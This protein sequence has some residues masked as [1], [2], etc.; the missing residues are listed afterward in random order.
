[1]LMGRGNTRDYPNIIK[2]LA[3]F[4][5]VDDASEDA[6]KVWGEYRRYYDRINAKTGGRMP[7]IEALRS[8]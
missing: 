6:R 8:M 5:P 4:L 3:R 1:M 2:R 7:T